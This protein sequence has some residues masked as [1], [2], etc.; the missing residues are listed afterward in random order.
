MARASDHPAGT[1]TRRG[2]NRVTAGAALA[3]RAYQLAT[4]D[5]ATMVAITRTAVQTAVRASGQP[6][7]SRPRWRTRLTHA[8]SRGIHRTIAAMECAE[9]GATAGATRVATAARTRCAWI[10]T[11]AAARLEWLR[12]LASVSRFLMTWPSA[13]NLTRCT[14]QSVP[15]AHA[16]QATR[17][18]VLMAG[19]ILSLAA[20]IL[21]G[22]DAAHATGQ[23]VCTRTMAR[24]EILLGVDFN[25]TPRHLFSLAR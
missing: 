25:E 6:A 3:H 4:T 19:V 22:Q 17:H 5:G 1:R 8:R 20:I 9:K 12:A 11:S 13:A 2:T 14:Q 15:A 16:D 10:M 24:T 21:P 18:A 23:C 7:P